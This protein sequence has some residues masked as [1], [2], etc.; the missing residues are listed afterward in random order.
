MTTYI[1]VVTSF[2]RR[3]EI[4]QE[5]A[6]MLTIVIPPGDTYK[7][8]KKDNGYE[9]YHITENEEIPIRRYLVIL[10]PVVLNLE[11]L[12]GF[13]KN[14]IFYCDDVIKELECAIKKLKKANNY[15]PGRGGN[16]ALRRLDRIL[17]DV[18]GEYRASES[19]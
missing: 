9:I 6:E 16:E 11:P 19:F 7:T 14:T 15:L 5:I 12:Y 18:P 17:F 3:R 8:V 4:A 13:D 2:K 10:I 1:Y